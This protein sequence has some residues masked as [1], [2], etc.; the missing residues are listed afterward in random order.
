MIEGVFEYHSRPVIDLARRAKAEGRCVDI[1]ARRKILSVVCLSDGTV[2][3]CPNRASTYVR[4]MAK[5]GITF[6]SIGSHAYLREDVIKEITC[7]F[8]R[9]TGKR[10]KSRVQL[11]RI[12]R[13]KEQN[14]FISLTYGKRTEHYFIT[15]TGRMYGA[16][17]YNMQ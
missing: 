14:M 13:A 16:Y 11:R 7:V 12:T 6:V 9:T 3:L 8:D 2:Y 17:S 10:I 5:N 1:T 15:T 4:D